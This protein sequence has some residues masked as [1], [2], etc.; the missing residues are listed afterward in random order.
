M[1]A[2]FGRLEKESAHVIKD[3]QRQSHVHH[4]RHAKERVG[5]RKEGQEKS[6]RSCP[7]HA[8]MRMQRERGKRSKEDLVEGMT[9]QMPLVPLEAFHSS[10]AAASPPI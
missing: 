4:H 8:T 5:K 9:R 2:D 6:S 3:N 7:P 10:L 1:M